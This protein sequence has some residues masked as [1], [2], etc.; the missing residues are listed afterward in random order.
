MN[1]R[2]DLVKTVEQ[3]FLDE[4]ISYR[5]SGDVGIITQYFEM[6]VRGVPP[7]P[8]RVHV[9]TELNDSLRYLAQSPKSKAREAGNMVMHISNLF[10]HGGDVRPYL[11]E[12]IRNAGFHDKCLWAYGMHHFHLQ[13]AVQKGSKFVKR[14]DYLLFAIVT[15]TDAF[16]I[17]VREHRDPQDLLW[18]RQNLVETV[19]TNWPD[20]VPKLSGVQGTKFTDEQMKE[21]RRKNGNVVLDIDGTAIAP[22]GM[23]TTGS[24]NSLMC[25]WWAMELLHRIEAIESYLGNILE[26]SEKQEGVEVKFRL[27]LLEEDVGHLIRQEQV[28]DALKTLW[29]VGFAVVEETRREVIYWTTT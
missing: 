19:W 8:R 7:R 14:A 24:G 10:E 15:D 29:K 18:V 12:E 2:H 5:K 21:L 23:G 1:F 27:G 11:S 22:L 3:Y 6:Q 26:G 13:E 4:K 28:D 25:T 16:L 17:D 20:I 9:S